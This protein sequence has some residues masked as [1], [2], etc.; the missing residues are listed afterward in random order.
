MPRPGHRTVPARRTV[1]PPPRGRAR[2]VGVPKIKQT[3][4]AGRLRRTY[5]RVTT[6]ERSAV[7]ETAAGRWSRVVSRTVFHTLPDGI[8]APPRL[9]GDSEIFFGRCRTPGR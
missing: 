7:G 2:R 4:R 3:P 6:W 8:Y 9:Q 1:M 5:S